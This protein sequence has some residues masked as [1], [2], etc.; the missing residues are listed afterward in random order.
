MGVVARPPSRVGGA[1]SAN[2]VALLQFGLGIV[3]ILSGASIYRLGPSGGAMVP[4]SAAIWRWQET[5]PK[6]RLDADSH[7]AYTLSLW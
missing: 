4:F 5:R 7:W 3:T 1:Q 2:S 6:R